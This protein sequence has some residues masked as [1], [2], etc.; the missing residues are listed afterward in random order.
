M[1][2]PIAFR[3][4]EGKD[5]SSDMSESVSS[6]SNKGAGGTQRRGEEAGSGDNGGHGHG[7]GQAFSFFVTS[8]VEALPAG[9]EL[10]E[11]KER[12]RE[13][14]AGLFK[15]LGGLEVLAGLEESTGWTREALVWIGVGVVALLL[16]LSFFI[17]FMGLFVTR[18]VGFGFPMVH[19]LRSLVSDVALNRAQWHTYWIA[20]SFFSVLEQFLLDHATSMPLFFVFKLIVLLFLQFSG[21]AELL[22][23]VLLRPIQVA[24]GKAFSTQGPKLKSK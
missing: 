18:C 2:Q 17:S 23:K 4:G 16:V 3:P 10:Q 20:F 13:A 1:T 7:S 21:G 14:W 11:H 6:S 9:E 12:V 5:L 19:C 8:V 22:Y 15:A 24:A